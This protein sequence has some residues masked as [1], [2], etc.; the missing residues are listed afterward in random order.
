[1][2]WTEFTTASWAWYIA[3]RFKVAHYRLR[4]KVDKK[5]MSVYVYGVDSL[6]DF[7]A[8]GIV[9]SRNSKTAYG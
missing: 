5:V 9:T 4:A 8:P 7:S 2:P 3:G 1:M 6:T